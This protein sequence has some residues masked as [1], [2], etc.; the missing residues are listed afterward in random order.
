MKKVIIYK[1][2]KVNQIKV[3]KVEDVNEYRKVM[4]ILYEQDK[5]YFLIGEIDLEKELSYLQVVSFFNKVLE[6]CYP[7]CPV[8]LCGEL[9]PIATKHFECIIKMRNSLFVDSYIINLT[10]EFYN[11]LELFFKDCGFKIKDYNN[12]RNTFWYE[13]EEVK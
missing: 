8:C 1:W 13:M 6:I 9:K 4:N 7:Q 10:N 12:T 11:M 3:H 5:E 2:N